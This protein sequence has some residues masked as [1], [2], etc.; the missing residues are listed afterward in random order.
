M[1]NFTR[2]RRRLTQA[3][4][5]CR[6]MKVRCDTDQPA[7]TTCR[8]LNVACTFLTGNKKR[9]PR[10]RLNLFDET[11]NGG[12]EKIVNFDQPN[13]SASSYFGGNSSGLSM[14]TQFC[15]SSVTLNA[16]AVTEFT[17]IQIP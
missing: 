5:C 6:R 16:L 15:P 11:P 12:L 3:C 10:Q 13:H 2:K 1:N 17:Q 7:C 4:D 14:P 8:R 9:G